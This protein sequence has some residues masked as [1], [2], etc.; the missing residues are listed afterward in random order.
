MAAS[1]DA[2][3]P[4]GGAGAQSAT[5]PLTW[6]HICGGSATAIVIAATTFTGSSNA[7]TAVTYGGQTCSLLQF[8]AFGSAG[9]I[10][11][12][13]LASP[14]TGS[15]TA[16][17]TF[18]GAASTIGGSLSA[19]GSSGHGTVFTN[20]SS[21][22]AS[23]TVGVTGTTT[24]GLVIV[25]AC[26]GGASGGGTFSASGDTLDWQNNHSS[27]SGADNAAGG[28]AASAGG[29]GTS[30]VGFSNSAG[31]DQWAMIAVELLPAGGTFAPLAPQPGGKTWRRIHRRRKTHVLVP[32]SPGFEGWGVPM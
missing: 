8:L 22:A 14:P 25:S 20:T 2:I 9:G 28:H 32:P 24:G 18:T 4:A 16:S 11:L 21:G 31:S 29:G 7:V 30:T 26:Y 12:Y 23:L 1:L 3:G 15:N 5:S 17:V 10:A 27:T 19:L 6:A 13:Y